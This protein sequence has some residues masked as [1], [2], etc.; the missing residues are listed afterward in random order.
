MH[1]IA[2]LQDETD[3][4]FF[5]FFSVLPISDLVGEMK[6]DSVSEAVKESSPDK[7]SKTEDRPKPRDRDKEKDG[8]RDRP[9]HRSRSPRSRRRPRSRSRYILSLMVKPCDFLS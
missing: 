1:K 9:R 2:F 3:F 7:T 5:S 4:F 8:R 6:P